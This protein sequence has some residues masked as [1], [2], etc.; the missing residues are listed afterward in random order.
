M[1]IDAGGQTTVYGVRLQ[2]RRDCCSQWVTSFT[3]Q[4]AN[5]TS[6]ERQPIF[7]HLPEETYPG[8]AGCDRGTIRSDATAAGLPTGTAQYTVSLD[9]KCTNT[10]NWARLY[11]WGTSHSNVLYIDGHAGGLLRHAWMGGHRLDYGTSSISDLCDGSWHTVGTQF[12]GATRRIIFDGAIVASDTP[13]A[14]SYTHLEP[15]RPY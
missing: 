12:D 13:G 15:T 7:S 10:P 11:E 1:S 6:A 4:Y 9:F 3:A 5:P 8:S 2:K 14:V